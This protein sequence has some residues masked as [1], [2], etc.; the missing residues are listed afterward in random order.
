LRATF[1]GPIAAVSGGTD[2]LATISRAFGRPARE[3]DL[4]QD[5]LVEHSPTIS[6]TQKSKYYIF[7]RFSG[8]SRD[9]IAKDV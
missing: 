8:F 3:R 9:T 5:R 4:P 6:A 7:G 1:I 2:N